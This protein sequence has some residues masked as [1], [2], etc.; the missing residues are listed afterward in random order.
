MSQK[1]CMRLWEMNNSLS[2]TKINVKPITDDRNW[3]TKPI[4]DDR[5]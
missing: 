5:N 2:Q 1:L 3:F 4:T